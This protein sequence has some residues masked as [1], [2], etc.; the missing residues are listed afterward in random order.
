[1]LAGFQIVDSEVEG[2]VSATPK[3]PLTNSMLYGERSTYRL[4]QRDG[5]F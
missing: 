4:L 1:M 5:G 2:A 3:Y